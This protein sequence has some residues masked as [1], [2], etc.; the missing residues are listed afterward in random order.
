MQDTTYYEY[1]QVESLM[2]LVA[3]LITRQ[4]RRYRTHVKAIAT[5][6]DQRKS[7]HIWARYRHASQY[8]CLPV[9]SAMIRISDVNIVQF[10]LPMLDQPCTAHLLYCLY[11]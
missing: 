9:N 5:D 4:Q 8:I 10:K 3:P 2:M 11:Q 1:K 6:F 7:D